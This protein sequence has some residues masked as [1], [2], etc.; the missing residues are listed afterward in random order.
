MASSS[1]EGPS[2]H[3]PDVAAIVVALEGVLADIEQF[4]F[5]SV[6]GELPAVVEE[7]LTGGSSN[8]CFRFPETVTVANDEA[9]N[10]LLEIDY[11]MNSVST[12]IFVFWLFCNF[13]VYA[14]VSMIGVSDAISCVKHVKGFS[15]FIRAL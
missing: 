12:R 10:T 2:H 7:V 11:P 4:S 8:P 3:E 5:S 13:V 15:F 14:S 9:A 1:Q 6:G